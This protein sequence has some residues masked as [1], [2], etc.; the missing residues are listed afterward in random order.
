MSDKKEKNQE[1]KPEFKKLVIQG[2]TYLTTFTRKFEK[3]PTWLK[4]DEKKIVSFIPGTVRQILVKT[5][6]TVKAEDKLLVL[7][8]MK[9]MNIMRAPV[10]GKIRAVH[11]KEGDRLPKGSTI[12]EFE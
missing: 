1:E 7:E 2:D 12:I 11:V 8:A 5:G 4:P 3:R 9:M 6:D 10:A